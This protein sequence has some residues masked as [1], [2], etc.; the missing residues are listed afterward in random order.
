MTNTK[1]I[2]EATAAATDSFGSALE[3]NEKYLDS[4]EG[5]TRKFTEAVERLWTNAINTDTIK[6]IVDFGTAII[7]LTDEFGL[8]NTVLMALITTLVI[9]KK[10]MVATFLWG[11]VQNFAYAITMLGHAFKSSAVSAALFSG[12][13]ST[14]LPLLALA[15]IMYGIKKLREMNQWL[16]DTKESADNL[17]DALKQFEDDPTDF[18]GL[19]EAIEDIDISEVNEQIDRYNQLIR[20]AQTQ[21]RSQAYIDSLKEE[22][23]VWE[24]LSDKYYNAKEA[25]SLY[26]RGVNEQKKASEELLE[27]LNRISDAVEEQ[28]NKV[29]EG[30]HEQKLLNAA[31]E[32]MSENGNLSQETY[33]ALIEVNSDYIEILGLESEELIKLLNNNRIKSQESIRLARSEAESTIAL[34]RLKIEA[35]ESE[36]SQMERYLQVQKRIAVDEEEKSQI[37]EALNYM[38]S[39]DYNQAIKDLETAEAK[40]NTI[41][42]AL[43]MFA[44]TGDDA[45]DSTSA[46]AQELEKF[47]DQLRAI[48][49]AKYLLDMAETSEEQK[50]AIEKL[51]LALKNYNSELKTEISRLDSLVDVTDGISSAEVEHINARDELIDVLRS[52]NVEIKN[53]QSSYE[54]LQKVEK[55][56]VEELQSIIKE[57]ESQFVEMIR[58]REELQREANEEWFKEEKESYKKAHEDKM[59][60]Y[61][62]ELDAFKNMIDEKKQALKD[63]FDEEDYQEELA[64]LRREEAD[65]QSQINILKLRDDV[66]AK[67]KTIELEKDLA[68]KRTEISDLQREHERDALLDN[69]DK[70]L[71]EQ[72]DYYDDIK[73][74]EERIYEFKMERLEKE[75]EENVARLDRM[76]TKE[77]V[78]A[79]A[80]KMLLKGNIQEIKEAYQSFENEFGEGLSYL[81]DTVIENFIKKLKEARDAIKSLEG[82]K[83]PSAGSSS[84]GGGSSTGGATETDIM[85]SGGIKTK[86]YIIGGKT[87]YDPEGKSRVD[88]GT[89]VDT[90][91][92][93]YVLKDDG[94]GEKVSDSKIIGS[95]ETGT[96]NVPK[97][98]L[99]YIHEGE[100]IIPKN[101]N[102]FNINNN[103]SFVSNV[104]DGLLSSLTGKMGSSSYDIS[105]NVA[106]SL[107]RDS[108][109]NLKSA[110]KDVINE[111]D[112]EKY[113]RNKKIGVYN[114]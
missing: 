4:I 68:E 2:T 15:G 59:E 78:Y 39:T 56:S 90:A 111:K 43:K 28:Y 25:L 51:V 48:S 64:G 93:T 89:Y 85:T 45:S 41:D 74:N 8:L 22:L 70:Q 114:Y 19:V 91:A 34:A 52:N 31:L 87:Y 96:T 88:P 109:P 110:I 24:N 1:T 40:I 79:E 46:T 57:V 100:A 95:Y 16:D 71:D 32:E 10:Q 69:L 47:Y 98:G 5:K 44:E 33:E 61:D 76:Y 38:H 106:G 81:G 26:T 53:L 58:K 83:M 27:E 7:N 92:G 49:E 97:D 105:I 108:I 30:T 112:R 14:L 63:Q 104:K 86:G 82:A 20:Q 80:R 66:E 12:V 73:S 55:K 113:R 75:Y 9:F 62:N 42:H 11:L 37:Q 29:K 67:A 94:T 13:L 65:I 35:Y 21:G 72:E 18:S 60:F 54:E 17:Y 77:K 107:D 36:M 101:F 23:S 6:N 99:A 102:P 84:G 3:E 103:S 50:I